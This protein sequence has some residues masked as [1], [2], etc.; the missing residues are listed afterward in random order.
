MLQSST[1]DGRWKAFKQTRERRQ[2]ERD[3]EDSL[4]AIGV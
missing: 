4:S 3:K 1:E 2:S